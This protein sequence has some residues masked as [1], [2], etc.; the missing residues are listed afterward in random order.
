MENILDNL[1]TETG[2]EIIETTFDEKSVINSGSNFMTGNGYLGYRGTAAEDDKEKYVGCF[3]TDTWDKA[4]G[5]WEE[6]C[7]VPNGLYTVIYCNG[8]KVS[9][10]TGNIQF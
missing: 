6:L 2:W 1:I 8:E 5:K 4:D 10:E 9:P 3:V 7:N